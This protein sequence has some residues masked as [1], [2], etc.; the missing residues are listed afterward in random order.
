MAYCLEEKEIDISFNE[1]LCHFVRFLDH[2][3]G[4]KDQVSCQNVKNF[5]IK[6]SLRFSRNYKLTNTFFTTLIFS[7]C[8]CLNAIVLFEER[9][10]NV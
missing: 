2:V 6:N 9:I 3:P 5:H 7:L 4:F 1:D 8:I 10:S